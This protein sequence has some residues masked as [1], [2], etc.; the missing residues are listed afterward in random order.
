MEEEIYKTIEEFPNYKVSN[1][2]NVA[3]FDNDGNFIKLLTKDKHGRYEQ[4]TFYDYDK[5]R[6]KVHRLVATVFVNKNDFKYCENEDISNIDLDKLIVNHKDENPRNNYFENL[7]WCTIKYNNIYGNRLNRVK[8][9]KVSKY[10]LNGEFIETLSCAEDFNKEDPKNIPTHILACCRGRRKS[11]NGFMWRF[12]NNDDVSNIEKYS[13]SNHNLNKNRKINKYDLDGKLIQT[14]NRV[15]DIK[16][17]DIVTIIHC[18]MGKL[19]QCG[20]YMWKF[21]DEES[22]PNINPYI[23]HIRNSNQIIQYDINKNMINI[24]PNLTYASNCLNISKSEIRKGCQEGC[25]IVGKYY[26]SYKE[27]K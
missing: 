26:F 9:N 5:K 25:L 14:Y 24:F 11:H 12:N 3:K 27:N 4:V 18:C 6:R 19:K 15:S 13:S 10:S 2:G 23:K 20:G 7:E 21:Q 8:N 22:E 16:K 17:Y 1:Y